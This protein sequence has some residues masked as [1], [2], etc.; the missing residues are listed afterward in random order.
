MN[1]AIFSDRFGLIMKNV[2]GDIAFFFFLNKKIL[3]SSLYI[4]KNQR[5]S[6]QRI[7][8]MEK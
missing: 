6:W 3:L 7:L 5:I 1:S 8:F 4:K 2:Y